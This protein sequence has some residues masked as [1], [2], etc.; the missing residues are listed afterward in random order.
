VAGLGL[1]GACG[2]ARVKGAHGNA[3]AT[4]NCSLQTDVLLVRKRSSKNTKFETASPPF[5]EKLGAKIKF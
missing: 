5:W 3:P 4:L 1:K 2:R